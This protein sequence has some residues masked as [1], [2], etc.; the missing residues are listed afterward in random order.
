MVAENGLSLVG[1]GRFWATYLAPGEVGG[2]LELRS[3]NGCDC[4]VPLNASA[5]GLDF[6]VPC[7]DAPPAVGAASYA[8]T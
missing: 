1:V 7:Y 6:T 8:A 3:T 2:G 5:S 4:A